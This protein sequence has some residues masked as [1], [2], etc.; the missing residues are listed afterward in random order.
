[1]FYCEALEASAITHLYKLKYYYSRYAIKSAHANFRDVS[2]MSQSKPYQT[3]LLEENLRKILAF[4]WENTL[5]QV[6]YEYCD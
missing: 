3:R 5:A 1:M 2:Q 6:I 4:F